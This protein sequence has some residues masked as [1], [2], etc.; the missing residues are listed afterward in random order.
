MKKQIPIYLQIPSLIPSSILF[1]VLIIDGFFLLISFGQISAVEN[2][3]IL[4]ILTFF[5]IIIIFLL[6]F[7]TLIL[8]KIANSKLNKF[9]HG[10]NP[11]YIVE[12]NPK[13]LTAQIS[14]LLNEKYEIKNQTESTAILE[15][16]QKLSILTALFLGIFGIIPGAI[17]IAWWS[18]LPKETVFLDTSK[19]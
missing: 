4:D 16:K 14:Q 1:I 15:R 13:N 19:Q 18:S 10:V 11:L 12:K 7:A 8:N 6:S 17:Y 9:R 5:L 3:P 2:P